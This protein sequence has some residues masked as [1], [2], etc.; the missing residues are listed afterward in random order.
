M[1]ARTT[2][3]QAIRQNKPEAKERPSFPQEPTGSRTDL[4]STFCSQL[5]TVGAEW[6]HEEEMGDWSV[7]LSNYYKNAHR[8]VT[9]VP[10]IQAAGIDMLHETNEAHDLWDI[11]VAIV[12]GTLGVAENGA[13]WLPEDPLPHRVLPFI[14]QHLIIRLHRKNLVANMHQAYENLSYEGLGFGLFVA[15]PSKTADIEQSLVKGA[16][17]ARTALVVLYI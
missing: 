16:Q 5:L 13:I 17:G 4:L 1:N 3:L 15:G 14:T 12:E 7:F 2:I 9:T 10:A 8:I 6:V 11:D